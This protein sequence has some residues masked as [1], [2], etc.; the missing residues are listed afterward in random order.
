MEGVRL[1]GMDPA[2]PW[3]TVEP[4][5]AFK[6]PDGVDLIEFPVPFEAGDVQT[7]FVQGAL[8]DR[9]GTSEEFV[10]ALDTLEPFAV[11]VEWTY[12]RTE[13]FRLGS[14]RKRIAK[15]ETRWAVIDPSRFRSALSDKRRIALEPFY[16]IPRTPDE[17]ER[18]LDCRPGGWAYLLFAGDLL[19]ERAKLDDKW[20]D[21]ELEISGAP[22][23]HLL[24]D[25]EAKDRAQREMAEIQLTLKSFNRLF[26]PEV[27][28]R[29]FGTPDKPGDP[30]RLAHI[31]KRIIGA[32]EELMD[33]AATLRACVV[34]ERWQGVYEALPR[35]AANSIKELHDFVDEVDEQVSKVPSI[36]EGPP[37]DEPIEMVLTATLTV[38]QEAQDAL[39][40]ELRKLSEA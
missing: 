7:F 22:R 19:S 32:Y 30:A 40:E 39:S 38:D 25:D 1:S 18:L 9:S 20:H 35:L 37:P 4:V 27:H 17:R 31:A 26:L 23:I 24:T 15:K 21:E 2:G 5:G 3:Q 8:N 33:W 13:S 36:L 11:E 28:E 12:L 10:S 34:P 29:V 6:N 14:R 16:G